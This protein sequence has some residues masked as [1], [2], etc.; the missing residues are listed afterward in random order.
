MEAEKKN[1]KQACN[2]VRECPC[3][4]KCDEMMEEGKVLPMWGGAQPG[5][6]PP[7][8]GGVQPGMQPSPMWGG[9]QP[10]MQTPPMW[11]GTQSGMQTPP[12][13]GGA[14]SGMQM[15][16][17]YGWMQTQAQT[18]LDEENELDWEKLKELYPKTAKMILGSVEDICNQM[19]YE[20][21]AMFDA[22][23]DK[24]RIKDLAM[25]IQTKLEEK[26]AAEAEEEPSDLYTMSQ[27]PCRNCRPQP[28]FLGDFIETMLYQEMHRRRC[29]NRRCRRW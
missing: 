19:E 23:P 28:N 24:N 12:M 15:P 3:F 9:V 25:Q 20:G 8:W 2:C 4:P 13:W 1:E 27:P 5:M 11:G 17:T 29:R 22:M 18:D 26:L 16:P 21:S 6:Q 14:Q 7:M 10:G